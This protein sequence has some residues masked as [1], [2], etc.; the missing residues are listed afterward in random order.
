MSFRCRHSK[1]TLV[2]GA[3]IEPAQPQGPRD[4]KTEILTRRFSI[5]IKAL[6]I[7][8]LQRVLLVMFGFLRVFSVATVTI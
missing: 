5:K 6:N 8:W 2:P 1:A 3:G 4:F 7:E